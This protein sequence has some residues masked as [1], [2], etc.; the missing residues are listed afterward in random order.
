MMRRVFAFLFT[1]AAALIAGG[2]TAW[3][4]NKYGL[5]QWLGAPSLVV[6]AVTGAL[7]S[8]LTVY[9][10]TVTVIV[11]ELKTSIREEIAEGFLGKMDIPNLAYSVGQVMTPLPYLRG[12]NKSHHFLLDHHDKFLK[13][14]NKHD[15]GSHATVAL[16]LVAGSRY[17]TDD[18]SNAIAALNERYGDRFRHFIVLDAQKR[19]IRAAS[20]RNSEGI[21]TFLLQ[22]DLNLT[23]VFLDLVADEQNIEWL[24]LFGFATA[25]FK[26]RQSAKSLFGDF[27]RRQVSEA[28]LDFDGSTVVGVVKLWQLVGLALGKETGRKSEEDI[29]GPHAG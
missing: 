5:P 27:H 12:A 1:I 15:A 29:N 2:L 18:F 23:R 17:T 22:R 3:L 14:L 21:I 13:E 26:V 24:D 19:N 4:A 28:L 8:G 7:G 9:L 16:S 10:I 11:S 6:D 25:S 20:S